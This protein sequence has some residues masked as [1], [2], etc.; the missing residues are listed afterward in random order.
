[1]KN[2]QKLQNP[3]FAIL[4]AGLVLAAVYFAFYAN[5]LA[6]G[7]CAII[8]AL[9]LFLPQRHEN[10]QID[11]ILKVVENASLGKLSSRV[12]TDIKNKKLLQLAWLV[13][14][15][16]DQIE[17]LLREARYAISA[18]SS[19]ENY[20]TLYP[21]G[22]K[23]EFEKTASVLTNATRA[24]A[25][26]AHFQ[27]IG[28]LSSDFAKINGGMDHNLSLIKD[29]VQ[30][31]YSMLKDISQISKKNALASFKISSDVGYVN[32][33]I[34]NLSALLTQNNSSIN[35]L[36]ENVESIMELTNSIEEIADQTN[37]LALNAA[38]ESARAGEYGRGFAVV[39]DEV[40]KL[41]QKTQDATT[42][43]STSL[44]ELTIQT[45]S[46]KQNSNTVE[47]IS[48]NSS[49]KMQEF[50]SF[51]QE[52]SN[53]L[54]K[55]SAQT[56]L[57]FL[58]LFLLTKKVSHISV[59]SKMYSSI[60]WESEFSVL[61]ILKKSE[62]STWYYATK[63]DELCCLDAFKRLATK[64]D[65]YLSFA[66]LLEYLLKNANLS[67]QKANLLSYLGKIEQES[68][69]I[70]ANLDNFANQAKENITVEKIDKF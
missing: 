8:L 63:D 4:F 30:K 3:P 16:L 20:R 24:I 58:S 51:L 29:N 50:S 60:L 38:I 70:F 13:N 64:H 28:A 36:D 55:T 41:A 67:S 48:S 54:E 53:S 10:L 66:N 27:T 61:E 25:Q 5:F 23:G 62:L 59:K 49:A 57:G 2:L 14:D 6:F 32:S 15:M 45:K 18:V 35:S 17:V 47:E 33:S 56:L 52:L 7:F 39:A 42:Q 9:G 43:I 31:S 34:Q 21:Q 40:R 11:E 12:S 22:L 37:L 68:E 44:K 19:G 26:N 65:E 69:E 46:I 1:M